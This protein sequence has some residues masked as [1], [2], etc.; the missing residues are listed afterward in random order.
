MQNLI[1]PQK[2]SNKTDIVL[3]PRFCFEYNQFLVFKNEKV[4]RINRSSKAF[5]ATVVEV[6][7]WT[8][9]KRQHIFTHTLFAVAY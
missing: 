2:R 6:K 9:H 1:T 8:A 3:K 7:I 4:V 5:S